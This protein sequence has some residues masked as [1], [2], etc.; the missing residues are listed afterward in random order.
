V[1]DRNR[2]DPRFNLNTARRTG[3]GRVSVC[4]MARGKGALPYRWVAI[5]AILILVCVFSTCQAQ[6]VTH[7]RS[8]W[9]LPTLTTAR[10]AH[11]LSNEEAIRGFPVHLRGVVTYFDPDFGTG[12]AAIFV[13]DATG[14][15]FVSQASKPAAQLFVGALVDVKGV[16]APGGLGPVID[17]PNIRILGRAPLPTNAPRV[18]IAQLKTGADDARWVEVEGTVHDIVE[19]GHDVLLRL[20]I[21]DGPIVVLMMKTPGRTYSQLVDSVVRIRGNA[22][23]SMNS[24]GQIIDFHLQAPNLSTLQVVEPARGDPFSSPIVPISKLLNQEYYFNSIH[25]IHLRGHV[26][27]QW[28]GSLICIRDA[29]RGICA[30][31][32][33][34]IPVA[35]NDLVDVAGFVET[36]N[37]SPVITNALFRSIANAPP[38]ASQSVTA[39]KVLAGGFGSELIQIDGLLIGY[40][41]AS[42]DAIL[43][44][45]SGGTLFPAI[46]PKSLS[47]SQIRVWKVGSRLR[48]TGIASVSVDIQNHVRAG[49]AAPQSF[50][51]LMRSPADVTL[52]E[53]PSWW[54]PA[55]A[56][57]VLALALACTLGVLSWVVILRKR[58]Q[59]QTVALRESEQRFRHLAQHDSLT[60][61]ASRL[62]LEDRLKDAV[63]NIRRHQ[64]GLAIMMVDLDSFKKINDTFG[65]QGGDEVLRVSAQRLLDAV[66]SSDTVVRLGGD[67]F[68]VLLPEIRDAGAAE[69]VASTVVSSLSR[70]ILYAGMEMPVSVSVGVE[71]TFNPDADSE[72]LMQHAD[73]ALYQAKNSG[74]HCLQV[75]AAAIENAPEYQ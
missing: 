51:L 56:L 37:H 45:S 73:A 42:S 2:Y 18:S 7:S 27:L 61:L 40:D 59:A 10:Q 57:I 1:D 24:D 29:E 8:E 69:L 72:A 35:V 41:Q 36:D 31:T 66:R 38:V 3:I 53:R 62:V 54:T 52:L 4:E 13:H 6:L 16:S 19:F 12:H 64:K 17:N 50:R 28:P 75:F 26:T 71:T 58:V 39:D 67:E 74:R 30:E 14:S 46:L 23:P 48:V 32:S 65:H 33:E 49:V 21:S 25:R 11:S 9:K 43:Q 34:T 60:G 68:V 47:G 20:E 55:H 63:E 44:L 70:P 5:V 22:A 15:I